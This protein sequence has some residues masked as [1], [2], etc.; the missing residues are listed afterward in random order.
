M[1]LVISSRDKHSQTGSLQ[2]VV[3]ASISRFAIKF[4]VNKQYHKMFRRTNLEF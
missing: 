4:Y 2:W 3:A 1:V